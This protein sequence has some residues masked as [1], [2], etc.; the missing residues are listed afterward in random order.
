[1]AR[2]VPRTREELMRA[3][4]PYVASQLDAGVALKHITRHVL[5]LFHAQPGGRAFR[6]ILSE[7]APKPESGIELLEKALAVTRIPSGSPA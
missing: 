5:G 1:L 7:G 6:Q 2:R 4:L 3:Y